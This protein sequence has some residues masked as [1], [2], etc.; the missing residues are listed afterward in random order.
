MKY[1]L[2]FIFLF[3]SIYYQSQDFSNRFD[4]MLKDYTISTK[5]NNVFL[6]TEKSNTIQLN[7]YESIFITADISRIHYTNSKKQGAFEIFVSNEMIHNK[8]NLK[9]LFCYKISLNKYLIVK[10]DNNSINQKSILGEK[11]VCDCNPL[12]SV[13][14]SGKPM[15]QSV[16]YYSLIDDIPYFTNVGSF[17]ALQFLEIEFLTW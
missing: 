7:N 6:F 9:N 13:L 1:F 12:F 3:W 8:M 11:N 17:D 5:V 16:F 15:P 14:D 2:H 4:D 10:V